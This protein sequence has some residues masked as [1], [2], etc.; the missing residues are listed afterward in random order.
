VDNNN[1]GG[2]GTACTSGRCCAP[3][4]NTTDGTCHPAFCVCLSCSCFQG[5]GPCTPP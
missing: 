5:G 1:C 4:I 2:C 3:Y